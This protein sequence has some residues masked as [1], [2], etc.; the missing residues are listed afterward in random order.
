VGS[1]GISDHSPIYLE[2]LGPHSKPKSPFKSNHVWLQDLGYIKL[3]T[4][5]CK[6]N[7]ISGHRSLA[8]GFC[9]NIS[10]LKQLSIT[11]AKEKVQRDDHIL[12]KI[13]P[14]PN[15]LMD[16][17][18]KG[19]TIVNE[20]SHLIELEKQKD[21]IL[22]EREES[23]RLKSRAIWLLAGDDNTKFFQ[24]YAK[25]RK[26]SNTIW[27][28]PLLDG[29]VADT[30]NKLSLLSTSHF[31]NLYKT[32]PGSNLADIIQVANHF[33]RFVDE[34]MAD[35]LTSPVTTAEPKGTLKWF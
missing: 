5:Y 18:N 14:K 23:C 7:P 26:V 9:H 29:G 32:P 27:N 10:H 31:Q 4:D 35:D 34:E 24:N 3:V 21:K 28:L 25:G 11:W 12:S 30:F 8:K 16:D 2:I 15:D 17:H 33:H 19:F 1:R 13:E 22:K 20:K 6:S